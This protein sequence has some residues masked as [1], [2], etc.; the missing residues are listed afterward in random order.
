MCI[1]GIVIVNNLFINGT[2]FMIK[3]ILY[4]VA[5]GSTLGP[6]LFLLHINGLPN[7][8][9]GTPR[10][11]ADDIC[12]ISDRNNPEIL[13]RYLPYNNNPEELR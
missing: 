5:Q 11:S 12:L 10:L 8:I 2:S 13:N 3:A 7:D 1:S 6:L 9:I 4:G